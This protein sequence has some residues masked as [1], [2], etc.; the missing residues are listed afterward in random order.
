M[1][2]DVGHYLIND[3]ISSGWNHNSQ[4]A[5]CEGVEQEMNNREIIDWLDDDDDDLEDDSRGRQ[6]PS[7]DLGHQHFICVLSIIDD[8]EYDEWR[9]KGW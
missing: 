4:F 3:S 8:P 7:L 1:F 6:D 9:E 5:C 2:T